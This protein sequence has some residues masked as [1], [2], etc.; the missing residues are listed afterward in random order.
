VGLK[1]EAKNKIWPPTHDLRS[2]FEVKIMGN[3]AR[4]MLFHE[5]QFKSPE[6]DIAAGR[7]IQ[8]MGETSRE[9]GEN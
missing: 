4:V 5:F 3:W 7:E 1:T 9:A 8:I 6:R 2:L